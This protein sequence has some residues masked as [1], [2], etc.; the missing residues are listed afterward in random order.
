MNRKGAA[1]YVVMNLIQASKLVNCDLARNVLLR[2][3]NKD[4]FAT[5]NDTKQTQRIDS[6]GFRNWLASAFFA[7]TSMSACDW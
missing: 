4:V 5:C 2:D 7:A 3:L 6:R 1:A